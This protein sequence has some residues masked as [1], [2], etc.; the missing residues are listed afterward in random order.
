[1]SVTEA[2]I[3]RVSDEV[4]VREIEGEIIIVPL[5]GGL[6]DMEDALYSLNETGRSIWM[7]L[8]GQR[9]VSDIVS[10]LTAEFE[11]DH[12]EI[13]ADVVGLLTELKSRGDHLSTLSPGEFS[14]CPG[15]PCGRSWPPSSNGVPHCASPRVA[16]A[17]I[18]TSGTVTFSPSVPPH[19]AESP[20]VRSWRS[21]GVG[22]GW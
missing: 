14:H 22:T 1:M 20:W 10:E 11:A 17:C 7:R 18:P 16:S 15:P 5:S 12:D 19:P 21:W 3:Y 13:E 8:D 6:G 2:D 9:S 4:V